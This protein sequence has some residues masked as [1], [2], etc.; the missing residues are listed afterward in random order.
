MVAAFVPRPLPPIASAFPYPYGT[1]GQ[2][3]G[4]AMWSLFPDGSCRP[5]FGAPV[6]APIYSQTYT[7]QQQAPIYSAPFFSQTYTPQSPCAIDANIPF[8][9]G[10]AIT[11]ALTSGG[12][13]L[14]VL[15]AMAKLT[16]MLNFPLATACI[17]ASAAKKTAPTPTK[18]YPKF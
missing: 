1:A 4:G 13:S 15:A 9:L 3:K 10:Q 14:Q 16:S 6:S 5:S 18:I 17:Q 7:P 11:A 12:A 2:G 8:R